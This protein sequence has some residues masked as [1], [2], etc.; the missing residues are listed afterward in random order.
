M[1]LHD[2]LDYRA[3][4]SGDRLFAIQG[5]RQMTY[6]E[7]RDETFKIGNALVGGGLGIGD[8]VA[9]LSKNSIEMALLYY[10]CSRA[11]AVPVPLNYRLAAPEWAYIINDSQS[12][13]LIAEPEFIE[14]ISPVVGDLET[15]YRRISTGSAVDNWE[16]WG[17]LVD[18]QPVVD[19]GRYIEES[20]DVYQ[21]YTS[22]TTGRPKGA[23][24]THSAVSRQLHQAHLGIGVR[25]AERVLVVAPMYHAAAGITTFAGV[26]AGGTLVI[27]EDFDPV[28]VVR[29]LS[30][31]GIGTALLVPAMIQFCLVAVPD[32]RERSYDSLRLLIYGASPIAEQTLR[33]AMN[34]FGCGFLQG[35]GMTETTAAVTYLMPADHE[36][37]LAGEPKLLLSAG[38]AL[39]GTEVAIFDDKDCRVP[40]GEIGEICARG[41]QM[42]RGYWHLDEASSE[43]LRGGWMHTGDAGILDDEG[44]LYIQDRVKDMIVSGGENV[45][46]REIEDVLYQHPAVAEAAVIGIPSEKWGE[47][48]KAVIVKKADVEASAED[49]IGF[50]KDRLGGYKQPRTVDFLEALPRNPSGKVLKKDL[51]E[52]YWQGHGRQVS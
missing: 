10:A 41:P 35:Y 45:Y 14:Q 40:N 12:K 44:Y 48:V 3:R 43:A 30:E 26:Q 2:F 18:G 39:L 22:G 37:A 34:V 25:D 1:R 27:Q 16:G 38:R 29:A 15:V 51:R 17:A 24:L 6:A 13:L 46:P 36:R 31:E 4:E 19:P 28:A 9:I 23:V 11:G 32:V 5:E 52:P 7:A 20:A 47:E 50:C 33:D 49:I 21:M 8:R 42:M